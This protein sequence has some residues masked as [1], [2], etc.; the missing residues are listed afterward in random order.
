LHSE[1]LLVKVLIFIPYVF[2]VYLVARLSYNKF[3]LYFIRLKDVYAN[4]KTRVTLKR[5]E[6][7]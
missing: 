2:L 3:E 4:N 6:Q 7:V 5:A 1:N